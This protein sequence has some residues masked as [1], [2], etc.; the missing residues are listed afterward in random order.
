MDSAVKFKV[1]QNIVY[2]LQGVGRVDALEE[3]QFNGQRSLYYTIYLHSFDMTVFVPVEK[4]IELGLRPIV[5]KKKAKE[6]L[7]IISKESEPMKGDWKA[8][9]QINRDLLKQGSVVDIATVVRA[10]YHRS[11]VKELPVQ[12]RKL[13]DDALRLLVDEISASLEQT[14]K[15]V[16]KLIY[17]QLEPTVTDIDILYDDDEE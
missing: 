4:A 7:G 3:R 8:R 9:Y 17:G 1:G 5:S 6:A 10:L 16:E 14:N 2:P 15:E 11:K 12:E 13:F